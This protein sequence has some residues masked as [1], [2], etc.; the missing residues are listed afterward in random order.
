MRL[1]YNSEI[2]TPDAAVDQML[3]QLFSRSGFR[4]IDESFIS[5]GDGSKGFHTTYQRR[6]ESGEEQGILFAA[7]RGSQNLV[8]LVESSKER[9]QAHQEEL[10]TV[11]SSVSFAVGVFLSNISFARSIRD[12]MS[13]F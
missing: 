10:F 6:G 12:F 3:P 13:I 8:I 11:I 5:H 1:G 7:I 2:V 9:I 4:T